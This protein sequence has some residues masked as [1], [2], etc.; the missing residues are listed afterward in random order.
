MISIGRCGLGSLRLMFVTPWDN[1]AGAVAVVGDSLHVLREVFGYFLYRL[2]AF[3]WVGVLFLY[4]LHQFFH[5]TA[6]R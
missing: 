5:Q 1:P 6:G 4:G 3:L 2:F